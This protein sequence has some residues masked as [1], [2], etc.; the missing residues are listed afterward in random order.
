MSRTALIVG[1]VY[2]FG[3]LGAFFVNLLGRYEIGL[4]SA[5]LESAL[6][7]LIWPIEIIRLFL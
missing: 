6:S 7:A 4:G 2:G 1:V 5:L 3:F